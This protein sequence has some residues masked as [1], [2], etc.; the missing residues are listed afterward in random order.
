VFGATDGYI[1]TECAGFDNLSTILIRVSPSGTMTKINP[2]ASA[3]LMGPLVPGAGGTMWG[4]GIPLSE[5]GT[6]GA[7]GVTPSGQATLYPNGNPYASGGFA[8]Q[9]L[10][11]NDTGAIMADGY[12]AG[13]VTSVTCFASISSDG[14]FTLL[15]ARTPD[16]IS[17][18]ASMDAS[19][20][21]WVEITGTAG[22]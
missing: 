4:V 20:D 2:P 1:W 22:G 14:T 21:A 3:P 7:V 10:A 13:V 8:V 19:G 16:G 11:G 15:N 18:G 6:A 5:N 12:C 17:I 9:D